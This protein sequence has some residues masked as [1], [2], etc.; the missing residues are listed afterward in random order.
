M[1][2]CAS[3]TVAFL[4]LFFLL[5]SHATCHPSDEVRRVSE[6]DFRT[7]VF[8]RRARLLRLTSEAVEEKL[9]PFVKRYALAASL[10]KPYDIQLGQLSCEEF[11]SFELCSRKNAELFFYGFKGSNKERLAFPISTL[12]DENGIVASA[13]HLDLVEKV[14]IIQNVIELNNLYKKCRDKCD[15]ILSYHNTLGT[16]EHSLFLRTAWRLN[17]DIKLFALTTSALASPLKHKTDE[18]GEQMVHLWLLQCKSHKCQSSTFRGNFQDSQLDSFISALD[19]PPWV[20]W[21]NFKDDE[22]TVQYPQLILIYDDASKMRV[23]YLAESLAVTFRGTIFIIVYSIGEFRQINTEIELEAPSM[24]F[25]PFRNGSCGNIKE[26]VIQNGLDNVK[27]FISEQIIYEESKKCSGHSDSLRRFVKPKFNWKESAIDESSFEEREDQPYIWDLKSSKRKFR[28]QCPPSEANFIE[29]K[30]FYLPW[31]D[32]SKTFLN[33]FERLQIIQD[34]LP[35]KN[36]SK[37]DCFTN[38]DDCEHVH[39][40]P[41]LELTDKLKSF[42]TGSLS[43]MKLLNLIYS[44]SSQFETKTFKLLSD[45]TEELDDPRYKYVPTLG[46]LL[47]KEGDLSNSKIVTLTNVLELQKIVLTGEAAIFMENQFICSSP[48]FGIYKMDDPFDPYVKY[49]GHL[50]INELKN[51]VHQR[52]YPIMAELTAENFPRLRKK[53]LVIA[54]GLEPTK[55]IIESARRAS[56]EAKTWLAFTY[57]TREANWFEKVRETHLPNN[58]NLGLVALNLTRGCSF[59]YEGDLQSF[60]EIQLWLQDIKDARVEPSVFLKEKSW[61]PTHKA[62]DFLALTENKPDSA[63]IPIADNEDLFIVHESD[64]DHGDIFS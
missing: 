38:R 50:E 32:V 61:K 46:L 37:I 58:R 41:T 48:C 20:E 10:L 52:R 23:R 64:F 40:F 57:I 62:I 25:M 44:F 12:D 53:L 4:G 42:R 18:T 60:K 13:L 21:E 28:H 51:F 9:A 63:A 6:N 30:L 35:I 43:W 26:G 24:I 5:S 1:A 54:L 34:S 8:H 59:L 31:D 47:N 33:T 2:V 19:L 45:L 17:S 36:I 49:S 16:N 55:P 29:L 22:R 15:I 11:P 39:T 7:F 14:P 27:N 3:S 56:A